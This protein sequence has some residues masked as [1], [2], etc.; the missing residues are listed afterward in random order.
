MFLQRYFKFLG[1]N[2]IKKD[3]LLNILS[4]EEKIEETHYCRFNTINGRIIA[5]VFNSKLKN[6]AKL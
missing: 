1:N 2:L 5:I 4:N 3:S 6:T